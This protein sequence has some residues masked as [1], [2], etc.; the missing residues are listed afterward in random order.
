MPVV[1]SRTM[2]SRVSS[3][4]SGVAGLRPGGRIQQAR[5]LRLGKDVRPNALMIGWERPGI[6]Q[7]TLRLRSP[8]IQTEGMDFEH[9]DPANTRGE[10][11][12]SLAPSLEGGGVQIGKCLFD[13]QAIQRLESVR[14]RVKLPSEGSLHAY[15]P[16]KYGGERGGK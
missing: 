15:V 12:L 14:R 1:N 11:I 6:R 10:M 8:A 2:A 13:K 3:G 9:A 7:E 4:R 16:V 5:D